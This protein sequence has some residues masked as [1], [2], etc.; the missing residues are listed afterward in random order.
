M[1]ASFTDKE[2]RKRI[3]DA[4]EIMEKEGGTWN[5]ACLKSGTAS[6]T[7]AR[8]IKQF[9]DLLAR[10]PKSE[11]RGP[12]ILLGDD[13]EELLNPYSKKFRKNIEDAVKAWKLGDPVPRGFEE[14]GGEL[15]DLR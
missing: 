2:R 4:L 9:P 11:A 8:W 3:E 10:K 12:G 13:D 14:I 7:L 15:V 5:Q 1:R 6:G